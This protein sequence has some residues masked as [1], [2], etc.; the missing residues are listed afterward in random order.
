M[1][2]A[3]V[4]PCKNEYRRLDPSAFLDAI[5]AFPWLTFLFVDDGSTDETA[6]TLAFL[7]RQSPAVQALYLPRNVGKAEAV[8][9]G[10][11]N[12]KQ[13]KKTLTFEYSVSRR[14]IEGGTGPKSVKQQFGKAE[15]ILKKF[16]K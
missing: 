6:E 4:V 12:V 13:M 10:V 11:P 15:A 16:K 8:R 2:L 5:R 14:N 7:E 1:T 3:L 9:A